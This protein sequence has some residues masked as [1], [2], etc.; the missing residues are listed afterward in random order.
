MAFLKLTSVAF[1]EQNRTILEDISFSVRQGEK[2]SIIGETGSG[3]SS[4]L[5]AIAGLLAITSGR[6][7]FH[8]QPVFGPQDKLIP[9]HAGIAYLSQDFELPAFLRV[10]QVLRYAS[11][12]SDENLQIIARISEVDHLL[13]RGTDQLSGGE[14]HRVAVARLLASKP[15]L[16]LLDEPYSNLDKTHREVLKKVITDISR[17]LK[18]TCMLVSHDPA[19]VLSWSNRILVL[20]GGRVIEQGTPKEIYFQ[21]QYE[22]TAALTGDFSLVHGELAKALTSNNNQEQLLLRPEYLQISRKGRKKL[23]GEVTRV[24]FVG[25][26]Y[27]IHIKLNRQIISV[28]SDSPYSTGDAVYIS[29]REQAPVHS[30]TKT[31]DK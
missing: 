15:S 9:G 11:Q 19:E 13:Q 8:D 18:I 24:F 3:K 7:E 30:V 1:T 22:Y 4:L 25:S 14:R 23:V 29:L 21:P 16:L 27:D 10:E 2:V 6:I 12:L 5:K 26:H 20:K 31:D 17:Q 28:R